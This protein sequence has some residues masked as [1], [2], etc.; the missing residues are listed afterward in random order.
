[1]STA[2]LSESP[3]ADMK[4][5]EEAAAYIGVQASTMAYWACTGKYRDELPVA[6]IGKRAFYRRADLDRWL[7]S[8][9]SPSAR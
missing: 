7:E 6:R 9:F 1:M 5:R 8:R 3:L 2:C 4:P